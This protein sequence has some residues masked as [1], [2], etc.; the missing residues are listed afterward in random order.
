MQ[1]H[2]VEVSHLDAGK[3]QVSQRLRKQRK[4]DNTSVEHTIFNC[5]MRQLWTFQTNTGKA[6]LC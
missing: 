5:E 1:P 6:R 2:L 4:L 3:V